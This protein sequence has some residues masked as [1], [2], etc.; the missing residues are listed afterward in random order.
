MNYFHANELPGRNLAAHVQVLAR[1]FPAISPY[2]DAQDEANTILGNNFSEGG[3]KL[4]LFLGEVVQCVLEAFRMRS[5]SGGAK[6]KRQRCPKGIELF[7]RCSQRSHSPKIDIT[8]AR[9]E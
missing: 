7:P 9:Y 8:D 3:L 2:Q 5:G 1:A 6:R 4:R